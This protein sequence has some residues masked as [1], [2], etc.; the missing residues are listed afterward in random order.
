M[1]DEMQD[2]PILFSHIEKI[3]L[4]QG[5]IVV[6]EMFQ[7]LFFIDFLGRYVTIN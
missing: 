6:S 1:M 3:A 5:K 4:C 7:G 2:G